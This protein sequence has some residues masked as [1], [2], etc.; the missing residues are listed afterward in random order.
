MKEMKNQRKI[1]SKFGSLKI[2]I[3][4]TSYTKQGITFDFTEIKKITN[5]INN[6]MPTGKIN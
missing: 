4:L 5:I 1:K 2:L 3:I 6:Y